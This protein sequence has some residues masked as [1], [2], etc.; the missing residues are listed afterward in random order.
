[1]APPLTVDLYPHCPTVHAVR[2]ATGEVFS[3]LVYGGEFVFFP[4]FCDEAVGEWLHCFLS[5]EGTEGWVKSL[6]AFLLVTFGQRQ[7][8]Q[9]RL[10]LTTRWYNYL[11]EVGDVA[12]G[13]IE[14]MRKEICSHLSEY[15]EWGFQPPKWFGREVWL[16]LKLSLLLNNRSAVQSW[17]RSLISLALRLW[18]LLP[19]LLLKLAE[20]VEA[21]SSKRKK[22]ERIPPSAPLLIRPNIQPNSPNL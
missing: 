17:R 20:A 2:D 16:S 22:P 7:Y 8:G 3:V 9:K 15:E 14:H 11:S 1:M 12:D 4:K 6:A 5:P 19:L 10:S 13:D 21:A 18:Y